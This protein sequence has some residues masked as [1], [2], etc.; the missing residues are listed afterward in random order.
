MTDT[1]TKLRRV[2]QK[3]FAFKL[4]GM[5][6]P[7][8][9]AQGIAPTQRGKAEAVGV[10]ERTF[11]RWE[12]EYEDVKSAER[13]FKEEVFDPKAYLEANNREITE[14]LLKSCKNGNVL[15][16]KLV[17]QLL[18]EL[19]E[20]SETKVELKISA[21]ERTRRNLEADRQL[22]EG[23]YRMEEVPEE[24]SVLSE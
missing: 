24:P 9:G 21:D 8:L 6:P 14:G 5:T 18:G 15:A 13:E 17:K 20:K 2:N 11:I 10:S 12:R 7:A 23:G 22:R 3:E 16:I 1:Q 19:V 4:M